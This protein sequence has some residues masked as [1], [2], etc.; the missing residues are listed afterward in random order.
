MEN[1][2]FYMFIAGLTIAGTI[3]CDVV[4]KDIPKAVIA[5]FLV[6]VIGTLI[7]VKLATEGLRADLK[8]ELK[9][10]EDKMNR[11]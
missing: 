5:G 1:R 4:F 7:E 11:L 2:T 9:T 10:S 6:A 8:R 3:L